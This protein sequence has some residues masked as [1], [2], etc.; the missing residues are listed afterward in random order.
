MPLTAGVDSAG[1]VF[2]SLFVDFQVVGD[3]IA[4]RPIAKDQAIRRMVKAKV[5][6]AVLQGG[7]QFP[8]NSIP[9]TAVRET[10]HTPCNVP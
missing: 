2:A 4:L 8:N 7:G 6:H 10:C 9:L 1:E 5:F 3:V